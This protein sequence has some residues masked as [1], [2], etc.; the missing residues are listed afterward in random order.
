MFVH[1]ALDEYIT[2]G[3]T[4]ISIQM[5]KNT[6]AHLHKPIPGRGISG[7]ESQFKV[8]L[9]IDQ[10]TMYLTYFSDAL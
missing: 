4:D 7:F 5:F 3:E 9:S 6:I 1:D 8:S 10:P 2:C